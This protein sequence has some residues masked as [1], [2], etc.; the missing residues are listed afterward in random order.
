MKDNK[1]RID[2]YLNNMSLENSDSSATDIDFIS[3][4]KLIAVTTYSINMLLLYV[5]LSSIIR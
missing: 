3:T 1:E 5:M 4:M 2:K